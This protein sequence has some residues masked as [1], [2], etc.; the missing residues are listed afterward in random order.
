MR[1]PPAQGNLRAG[2]F[3]P[4]GLDDQFLQA[5]NRAPLVLENNVTPIAFGA[6]DRAV[7]LEDI[8]GRV[9]V[10]VGIE[11]AVTAHDFH[12]QRARLNLAV[13]SI[14]KALESWDHTVLDD[15]TA[16]IW[17]PFIIQLV[18]AHGL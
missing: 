1:L 14:A 8:L 11:T 2:K 17:T 15:L 7:I 4:R 12:S 16:L 9:V 5:E 6:I 13:F 10:L 3:G 18:V